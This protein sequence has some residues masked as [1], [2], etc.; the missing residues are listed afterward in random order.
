MLVQ[1][2]VFVPYTAKYT[3]KRNVTVYIDLYN[4]CILLEGRETSSDLIDHVV[5]LLHVVVVQRPGV[6]GGAPPVAR[7]QYLVLVQPFSKY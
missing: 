4:K 3:D 6:D 2:E 5:H 1:K 7:V